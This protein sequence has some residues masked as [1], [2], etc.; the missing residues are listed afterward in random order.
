MNTG[1]AVDFPSR[2]LRFDALNIR[3]WETN[4]KDGIAQFDL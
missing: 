1:H 4:G 3:I 2:K